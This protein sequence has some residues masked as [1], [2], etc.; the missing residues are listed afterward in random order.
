ME[1]YDQKPSCLNTEPHDD[2]VTDPTMHYFGCLEAWQ[3]DSFFD[4]ASPCWTTEI[5]R[6]EKSG[7]RRCEAKARVE[8]KL[9][10][11]RKD[12]LRELR[13]VSLILKALAKDSNLSC[14]LKCLASS[15]KQWQSSGEYRSGIERVRLW[16]DER[17]M[18][19]GAF[20]VSFQ[21]ATPE[22][23][24]PDELTIPVMTFKNGTPYNLAPRCV[25]GEF[26]NQSTNGYD[27][28]QQD[29]SALFELLREEKNGSSATLTWIHIPSNNMLWV[30]ELIASYY[31]ERRPS[32]NPMRHGDEVSR[33]A[34]VLREFFWK[35][36]QHGNPTKPISR[37]MRPFCEL[38]AP[39]RRY[40]NSETE[41][42]VLYAPFLHW[43]TSRQLTLVTRKIEENL[44]SYTNRQRLKVDFKRDKRIEERKALRPAAYPSWW[45]FSFKAGLEERPRGRPILVQHEGRRYRS[46][47]PLGQYLLNAAR[48]YEEVRNYE[49]TLLIQKYLFA[50]PPLHPRRTLDQGYYTTV[51]SRSKGQNQVVYRATTPAET[52]YHHYDRY[53]RRWDCSGDDLSSEGCDKCRANIRKVS[54]VVMV[55][56]LWMWILDPGVIITC[57]P[58]RYGIRGH[59]PSGVF[60]AIQ[61]RLIRDRPIRSVFAIAQTILDECSNTFFDRTK[62]LSGQPPVLDIFSEA[63]QDVSRKQTLESHRLWNWIDRARRIN[64]QQEPHGNIEIPAWNISAEG[65]LEREIQ[66][67]IEE[68]EIMISI[69][70][71]QLDVCKKFTNH[72]SA[73]MKAD[74]GGQTWWDK[75]GEA[76]N[77]GLRLIARMED[78]IKFLESM[79]KTASNASDQVRGLSQLRQ[80]QDSVIQAL[81]SVKLS[82]DSIDQGRTIMVFT[83]VTII[84]SP[85]S[86]LSSIFGMNNAE[87]GDNQW[88]VTDQLKL[89]LSISVGVTALALVFAS[90]RVR[91]TAIYT[92]TFITYPLRVL[93]RSMRSL[94]IMLGFVRLIVTD[95]WRASRAHLR[96][97]SSTSG[98]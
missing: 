74:P 29:T 82:R 53:T 69:N 92:V 48:L 93:W 5:K 11:C 79:L 16:R 89:I 81:Q 44:I 37:F 91:S 30:E 57:F 12:C 33:A 73:L 85:L 77:G 50:D 26:P 78:R 22:S 21:N 13:R 45:P 4:A 38:I 39:S 54:S 70:K 42:I 61:R 36:Q 62:V 9:E 51:Q 15:R 46:R 65:E 59:D 68:L 17:S 58:K 52:S 56:Q 67:I 23:L 71:T 49:D 86:F 24:N 95:I 72:T 27:L 88:K 8:T 60:E 32:G 98:V 14:L 35:G 84:F 34:R 18:R 47:S 2:N 6:L 66:E 80:Q 40:M 63:I 19:N 7:L 43:E 20:L 25:T 97:A 10:I 28:L 76:L 90:R 87:F 64:R 1:T 75:E 41:K 3:R 31:G 83:T 96:G 55:D 94:S